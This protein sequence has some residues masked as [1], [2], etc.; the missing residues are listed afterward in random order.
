MWA[1]RM[2]YKTGRV[3]LASWSA[4]HALE[5]VFLPGVIDWRVG[6]ISVLRPGGFAGLDLSWIVGQTS[7]PHH[8][9]AG[10]WRPRKCATLSS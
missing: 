7:A 4:P 9:W 8:V 2:A 5:E 3:L 1:A 10:A 6:N